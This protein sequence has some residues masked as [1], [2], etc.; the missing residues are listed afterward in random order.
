MLKKKKGFLVVTKFLF[1]QYSFH[2]LLFLDS[3]F[4]L[5]VISRFFLS[6]R[7]SGRYSSLLSSRAPPPGLWGC[8]PHSSARTTPSGSSPALRARWT[9]DTTCTRP[10]RRCSTPWR[11]SWWALIV[12]LRSW[13]RRSF[14]FYTHSPSVLVGVELSCQLL[15]INYRQGS[16]LT[17]PAESKTGQDLTVTAD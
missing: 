1:V 2:S 7:S 3:A 12:L 17:L 14:L 4:G 5:M 15:M 11:P 16:E 6:R 9:A 10:T 13:H 8:S